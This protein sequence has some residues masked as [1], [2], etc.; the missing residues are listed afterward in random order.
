VPFSCRMLQSAVKQYHDY[1]SF[2]RGK[3]V[4]NNCPLALH[5]PTQTSTEWFSL[6][7]NPPPCVNVQGVTSCGEFSSTYK[8]CNGNLLGTT[9]VGWNGTVGQ[10]RSYCESFPGVSCCLFDPIAY[11]YNVYCSAFTLGGPIDSAPY[12]SAASCGIPK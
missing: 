2:Q 8:T 5:V 11:P 1:Q 9:D 6:V 10:C 7:D 3:R 12:T 4:T